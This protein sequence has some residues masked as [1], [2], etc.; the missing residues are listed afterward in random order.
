MI[1]DFAQAQISDTIPMYFPLKG[2]PNLGFAEEHDSGAVL[3]SS[4]IVQRINGRWDT[5]K[6]FGKISPYSY[7]TSRIRWF[8]RDLWRLQEPIIYNVPIAP[9]DEIYRFT[10]L[11]S[12]HRRIA[13]RLSKIGNH[14]ML[15]WKVASIPIHS[16]V[17]TVPPDKSSK[18][19]SRK[20]RVIKAR[21]GN[22]ALQQAGSQLVSRRTWLHFKKMMEV[23]GI[24]TI[25]NVNQSEIIMNDG[26]EWIL[27]HRQAVSY[28]V[29]AKQSPGE[30]AFK[31]CCLY[32]LRRTRISLRWEK[33][34]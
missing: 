10:W 6:V 3:L 8:S 30:S 17:R 28:H 15:S 20:A 18:H 1:L 33:I 22:G 11:R 14:Y 34:Y 13:V 9:N 27:E 16:G 25:S 5:S 29:V 4:L 19:L 32:L 2:F 26:S 12:F 24:D 31:R 21:Y 7:D 23:G